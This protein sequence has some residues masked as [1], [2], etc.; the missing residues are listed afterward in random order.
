YPNH[1][2]VSAI[3]SVS[4]VCSI[5]I[6]NHVSAQIHTLSL[7]DALPISISNALLRIMKNKPKIKITIGISKMLLTPATDS[8]TKTLSLYFTIDIIINFITKLIHN[9][10]PIVLKYL[11]TLK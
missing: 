3:L 4:N 7:H 9:K 8:F 10:Y 5:H 11:I 1:V 2:P 6:R